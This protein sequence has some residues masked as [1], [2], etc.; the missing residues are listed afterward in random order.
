[1]L[2][3]NDHTVGTR[4]G[5]P[6]PEQAVAVMFWHIGANSRSGKSIVKLLGKTAIFVNSG[7]ILPGEC[8]GLDHVMDA[9]TAPCCISPYTKRGEVISHTTTT[10]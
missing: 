10:E 3:P 7:T 9:E 8:A 5:Y 4:A 2:L 6:T 1:V